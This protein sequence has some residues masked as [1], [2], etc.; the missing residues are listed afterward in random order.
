M[1][2]V[3]LIVLIFLLFG[4]GSILVRGGKGVKQMWHRFLS[5]RE[6]M[7]KIKAIKELKQLPA[8]HNESEV[9]PELVEAWKEVNNLD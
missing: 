7:A 1:G 6:N 8:N 3:F 4:G 9:P 5:H 2:N